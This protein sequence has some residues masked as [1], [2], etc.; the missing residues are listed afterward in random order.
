MGIQGRKHGRKQGV[1]R[2]RG[3]EEVAGEGE[4]CSHR[5]I[6]EGSTDFDDRE[7]IE[8]GQEKEGKDD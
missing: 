4:E 5:W 8:T 7:S 3:N 2:W 6:V 1:G